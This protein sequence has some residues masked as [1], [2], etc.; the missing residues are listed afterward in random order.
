MPA[1]PPPMT[2]MS[3]CKVYFRFD[4][5]VNFALGKAALAGNGL[6]RI[7]ARDTGGISGSPRLLRVACP[8]RLGF[9]SLRDQHDEFALDRR[10]GLRAW[11]ESAAAVPRSTSSW[12]LVS[13]RATAISR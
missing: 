2:L 9:G 12:I 3:G 4:Q 1:S 13:S 5:P 10:R 8:R 7:H 11:R 6:D